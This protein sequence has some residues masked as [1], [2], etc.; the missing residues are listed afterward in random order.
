MRLRLHTTGS[1]PLELQATIDRTHGALRDAILLDCQG[2]VLPTL[3]LGRSDQVAMTIGPSVGS[4]SVSIT[5]DREKLTGEIQ[6]VQ[7]DVRIVPAVGGELVDVPI[8]G[9]L[10]ESLGRIDSLA[11]R[12][13]LGG[14]LAEPNCTLWS[15]LG[16]AVAEAMERAVQRAGGLHARALMVDAGNQVDEQLTLIER[17]MTDQQ[18]RLENANR[19]PASSIAIG[20][21]RRTAGRPPLTRAPRPPPT[22]QLVVSVDPFLAACGLATPC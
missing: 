4:L 21:R 22:D 13:S 7:K 2:I 12:V 10:E 1:L 17:Q 15:N 3:A 9:A 5:V 14:T 11:T 20:R 18:A 8:A 6:M 16:S 19:G